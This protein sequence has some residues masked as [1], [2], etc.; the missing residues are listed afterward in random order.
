MGR[1]RPQGAGAAGDQGPRAR[2]P[3]DHLRP[4]VHPARAP[5]PPAAAAP[6]LEAVAGR[7]RV[8]VGGRGA[9]AVRPPG[10]VAARSRVRF[11]RA[12]PG[13]RAGRPAAVTYGTSTFSSSIFRY[14][15][16]SPI[17]SRLA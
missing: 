2:V 13:E 14:S 4:G 8:R 17:P 5:G 12:G 3:A 9:G 16:L 10:A 7:P 1:V 6:G 11:R 15:E